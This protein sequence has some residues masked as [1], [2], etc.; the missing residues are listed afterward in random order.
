MKMKRSDLIN[1]NGLAKVIGASTLSLCIAAV[2][3]AQVCTTPQTAVEYDS[4]SGDEPDETSDWSLICLGANGTDFATFSGGVLVIDDTSTS[5]KA[6]Y[7]AD[8][9]FD[10]TCDPRQDAVYEFSC[11]AISVNKNAT[12]WL[13]SS[14]RFVF[15]CGM[16][17]GSNG[18]YDHD[19]R[20]AVSVDEGVV[21]F[22]VDGT[23]KADWL[24]LG[25][26][27]LRV[28]IDQVGGDTTAW[29]EPHLFR[30]EKD[31]TYV[32]LFVDNED[33][34]SITIDLDDL[35]QNYLANEV[36]LLSTSNPGKSKFELMH[37]RYRIATTNFS[38]PTASYCAG[39]VN[40]DDHV[41]EVDLIELLKN[42]GPCTGCDED[43]NGDDVVDLDDLDILLS[44]WGPCV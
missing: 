1:V 37:F 21:F 29:T 23:G 9:M 33:T 25:S 41:D 43:L 40:T 32:K 10:K 35:P 19:F 36:K 16:G 30:I 2:T 3:N 13:G 15:V 31:D 6:K 17:T 11:K 7:C 26:G 4:T 20:V 44:S 28:A 5:V 22:E 42:W 27:D 14:A 12:S 34:A 8:S 24:D 39:D 18:T 38:L